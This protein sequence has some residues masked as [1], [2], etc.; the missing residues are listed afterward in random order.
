MNYIAVA[1]TDRADFNND[2]EVVLLVFPEFDPAE[3]FNKVLQ[4]LTAASE[5]LSRGIGFY[6]YATLT[7]SIQING[8]FMLYMGGEPND[9]FDELSLECVNSREPVRVHEFNQ[10]LIP[11]L[12]NARERV[13]T[14]NVVELTMF[15]RSD[16]WPIAWLESAP[17]ESRSLELDRLISAIKPR[18]G[19]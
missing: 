3:K 11:L 7:T 17:N 18:E 9:A 8:S 6:H 10:E 13:G 19:T 12:E 1:L 2:N 14:I 4:A 5:H 15:M 16:G